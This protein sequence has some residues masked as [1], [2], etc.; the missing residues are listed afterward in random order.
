MNDICLMLDLISM[1]DGFSHKPAAGHRC[2][3]KAETRIIKNG[4]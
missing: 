3:R 4:L 2:K 1:V